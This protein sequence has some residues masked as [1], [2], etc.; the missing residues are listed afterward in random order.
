M[1]LSVSFALYVCRSLF[2]TL[3]QLT[4]HISELMHMNGNMDPSAI[5]FNNSRSPPHQMKIYVHNKQLNT[6]KLLSTSWKT[7]T[8][9]QSISFVHMGEPIMFM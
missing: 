7:K 9:S 3:T 8:Y 1:Y 4:A 5:N 6:H 2:S